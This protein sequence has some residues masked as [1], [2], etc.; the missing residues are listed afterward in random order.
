MGS[1]CSGPVCVL[2]WQSCVVVTKPESPDK[3]QETQLH[4]NFRETINLAWDVLVKLSV[5]YFSVHSLAIV[6]RD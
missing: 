2:Q 4:L 3:I 6:G 1:M 5:L